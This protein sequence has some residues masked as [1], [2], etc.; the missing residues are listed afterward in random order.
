MEL[1]TEQFEQAKIREVRDTPVITLI[2]RP[3]RAVRPDP[4]GRARIVL[5]ATS[6]GFIL[7]LTLTLA[8]DRLRR[9]LDEHNIRSLASLAADD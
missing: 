9:E 6:I 8:Q 4:A 1:L 5:G 2:D 7:A 3:V